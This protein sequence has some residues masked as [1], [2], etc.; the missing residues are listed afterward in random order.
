M[1]GATPLSEPV[2]VRNVV[3]DLTQE[4]ALHTLIKD[5]EIFE[6]SSTRWRTPCWYSTPGMTNFCSPIPRR[7]TCLAIP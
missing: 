6:R 1:D 7:A 3:V 4:T 5:E 2:G